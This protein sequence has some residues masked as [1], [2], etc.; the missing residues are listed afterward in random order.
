MS[1]NGIIE[2]KDVTDFAS[3]GQGGLKI[4]F[5]DSEGE[6]AAFMWMRGSGTENVFRILC[7]VKGSQSALESTL[8]NA[9]R[10]LLLNAGK[11]SL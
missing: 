9:E 6:S 5:F 1:T 10:A 2:T 4:V 7:D 11:H 3:S 8:L